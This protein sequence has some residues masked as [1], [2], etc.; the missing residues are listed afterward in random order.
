VVDPDTRQV[1]SG[2]TASVSLVI[3]SVVAALGGIPESI[4]DSSSKPWLVAFD[5][6]NGNSFTFKVRESNPDRAVD[7]VVCILELYE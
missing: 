1:L 4:A 3:S 5:D 7:L 6:I 2:R